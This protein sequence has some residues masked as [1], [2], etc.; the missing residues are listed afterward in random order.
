M[1]KE[2]AVRIPLGRVLATANALNSI[3]QEEMLSA[4]SRHER[5]DWG[6][7]D[8]HDVEENRQALLRGGRLFSSY[9]SERGVTFW[10]ITEH[11]RSVTTILLPE[12]Y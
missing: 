10:I 11:D 5:G 9:R 2:S 12:D 6:E 3:P 8:P 4:L 1:A 7:L